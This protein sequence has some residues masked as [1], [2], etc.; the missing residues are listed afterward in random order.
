[1]TER[2]V[3]KRRADCGDRVVTS[4]L[5]KPLPKGDARQRLDDLNAEYQD[6]GN[7]YIEKWEERR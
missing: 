5:T 3:V 1:M 6:P 2:Y 4:V 7:Y